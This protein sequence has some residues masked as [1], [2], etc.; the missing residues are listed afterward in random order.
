MT[1]LTV[2]LPD[3]TFQFLAEQATSQG[4]SSPAEYLAALANQAEAERQALEEAL[5][6][7]LNSGPARELT[8]VDWDLLKQRVWERHEAEYGP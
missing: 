7:G 8:R 4:F 5:M 1:M 6:V 2:E 3:S